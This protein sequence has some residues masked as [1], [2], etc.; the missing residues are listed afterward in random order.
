M[1]DFHLHSLVSFDGHDT[2]VAMARAAKEKGLREICFTDHIDYIPKMWYM[3]FDTA[4]YSASYDDLEVPGVTIRRGME[5]GL[6]PDN[7][8][9]F[10]KDLKRRPFDFVI[11][12]VHIVDGLDVYYPEFWQ[13]KTAEQAVE[14][15]LRETL[16]CVKAHEG[17]DVLGHLTYISKARANPAWAPVRCEE[18]RE[19]ADEILKTL[20]DKGIGLEL[21][22]SGLARSGD[23]LP[24]RAFLERYRE[25][26]GQIVTIGSDAH[27]AGRVGDHVEQGLEILKGVFGHVCT[28]A[29]RKPVFHKL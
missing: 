17:F 22:T 19:L 1:F 5:F 6:T 27:T 7:R 23:F 14:R 12:S 29:G 10:L 11:G 16:A 15:Y 4:V 18:Y 25:L 9:Q 20:V 3:A 24:P 21:N 13:G 8:E 26:G 2:S 28:F